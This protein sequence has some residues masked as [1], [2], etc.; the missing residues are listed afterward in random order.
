[1]GLILAFAPL[2]AQN[3]DAQLYQVDPIHPE[4]LSNELVEEVFPGAPIVITQDYAWVH[5]ELYGR[6]P[7]IRYEYL[8]RIKILGEEG[9]QRANMSFSVAKSDIDESLVSWRAVT[10]G[11]NPED[12]VVSFPVERKSLQLDK[13]GNEWVYSVEFPFV[14]PGSVIELRYE[15]NSDDIKSLRTW[16][17]QQDIPVMRSQITT[18]IPSSYVYLPITKGDLSNLIRYEGTFSQRDQVIGT[19]DFPASRNGI[20]AIP[21]IQ[22]MQY[23]GGKSLTYVL[24][25]LPALEKGEAFAPEA[26]NDYAPSIEWQLAQDYYRRFTN[27][28]L[29]NTWDEL[30]RALNRQFHSRRL[31]RKDRSVL[32]GKFVPRVRSSTW[33]AV[34]QIYADFSMF[35]WN[36]EYEATPTNLN[37]AW[38]SRE[39]SS[40]EINTLFLLA[41][42]EAGIEASPVL[43]STKDNGFVSAAYPLVN[44]FNHM[45]VAMDQGGEK[46]LLDVV[47]GMEKPGLLP[48]N[49]LNGAGYLLNGQ[50]GE[51][52][53]LQSYQKVNQV[54][55]SRFYMKD[56]GSMDGQVSIVNQDFSTEVEEKRLLE[57]GEDA[58][59]YFLKYVWS[60]ARSASASNGRVE[61]MP[62]YHNALKI[63]CDVKIDDYVVKTGDLLFLKP[64]LMRSL[65]TNPFQAKERVAP[66]DLTYPVWEAHMLGL[67]I[68]DGYEV[69]QVPQSIRV[70]MPGNAGQFTYNV[71]EMGNILHITST[72]QI[73]RTRYSPE[74]YEGIRQFFEYIVNKHQEDIVIKKVQ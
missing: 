13:R 41:L 10:Y 2:F 59:A 52:I 31:N 64:M 61:H 58:S 25:E 17:F 4:W 15:I 14:R 21:A 51:W 37:K 12:E 48:R 34:E 46:V 28:N 7:K 32:A 56:D 70:M 47:G 40:S 24:T 3:A 50:G 19:G 71:M 36:G 30:D 18:F 57:V 74:E 43:I 11:L 55:Y 45:L 39:G 73:N 26:V 20:T 60:G 9:V 1:M 27:E 49:D 54:T 68:P 69:A 63:T 38:K 66:I 23:S 8:R 5:L 16:Q 53:P 42:R 6:I 35:S 67:V 33:T 72:I 22:S 65:V 44:Q 62:E 29:Y